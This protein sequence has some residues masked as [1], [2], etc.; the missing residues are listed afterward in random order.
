VSFEGG[1][2]FNTSLRVAA[3]PN[4]E[5]RAILKARAKTVFIEV[6]LKLI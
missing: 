2:D 4:P 1:R 5:I 3:N 6:S